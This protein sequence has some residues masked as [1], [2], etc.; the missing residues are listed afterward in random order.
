M[1]TYIDIFS[2]MYQAN[3]VEVII[4]LV[5]FPTI[6]IVKYLNDKYK[7][8][9]HNI[10]F[11]IELVVIVIVTLISYFCRLDEPPYNVN[12]VKHIPTG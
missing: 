7:K 6:F 11:P 3:I 8:Q 12:T 1:Q 9:M 10:P 2:N 5:C 4:S